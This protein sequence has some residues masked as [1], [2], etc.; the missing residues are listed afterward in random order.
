MKKPI[1][2]IESLEQ[3]EELL[4]KSCSQPLLLFKHSNNCGVSAEALEE[5]HFHIERTKSSATYAMI[6][7]QTHRE[8]SRTIG[9][10][11]GVRHETPQAILVCNK[12]AT[13]SVSHFRVNAKEIDQALDN[14]SK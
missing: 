2:S 6:V 7:V 9:D 11:L 5:L 3:L 13:W 4:H 12:Q 1:V 8:L 14:V 10:S